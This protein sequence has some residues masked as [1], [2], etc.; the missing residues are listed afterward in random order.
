MSYQPSALRLQREEARR[1]ASRR[2]TLIAV[3]STIVIGTILTVVVTGAPGFKAVKQSF[4][5]WH[6]AVTSFPH[7]LSGLWLN[8]RVLVIAGIFVLI[9]GLLIALARTA[10]SPVL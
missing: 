7:V 5:N 1:R 3:F 2:S 10:H 9:I 8:L 4:F 6:Y